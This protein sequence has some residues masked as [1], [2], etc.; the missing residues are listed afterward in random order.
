[1]TLLAVVELGRGPVPVDTPVLYADDEGLLRGRAVFET[2]R[3]YAGTPFRLEA[4]LDRLAGSAA[5]L[6]LP[7]P[8]RAGFEEAA[9]AA[10][11][12]SGEGDL[13]LRFLWSAG[14]EGAGR[15]VGIALASTLPAGL[16]ELRARGLRLDVVEW[17][18][19]ALAGAKSTSYA[20][21]MAA[22]AQAQRHGAD[23]ALLVDP[24]DVVLEAPTSNV[25]LREGD[26]L[27]TPALELPI[28]AGI[29]RAA[30]LELAPAG[31]YAV[32]EAVFVLDRLVAADEVFTSSSVRE[33][34][35]VTAI[36][37]APVGDGVPG[38]AA[39]ALERALRVAA[40]YPLTR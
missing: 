25:W 6:G 18:P 14:R 5:R 26:L 19:G 23:D 36:G 2:L 37:G 29:T 40:G 24:A 32:E 8:D 15:P 31:G 7:A 27:V 4:H 21:N 20:A 1:M 30:L 3:V 10:V 16:E 12:A 22:Q 13:V 35:P 39:A 9:T 28:L 38:P 17:A 11:A 34:M 33:V